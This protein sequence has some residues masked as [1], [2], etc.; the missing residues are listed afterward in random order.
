MI[1]RELHLTGMYVCMVCDRSRAQ[2]VS[3]AANRRQGGARA[4]VMSNGIAVGQVGR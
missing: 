4:G 2:D 3:R 1:C